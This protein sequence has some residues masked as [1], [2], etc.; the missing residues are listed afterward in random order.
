MVWPARTVVPLAGLD[1][2]SIR[3]VETGTLSVLVLLP[4]QF[5]GTAL[6]HPPE[7]SVT[8]AGGAMVAVLATEVA[9]NAAVVISQKPRRN[10]Q[11]LD[12]TQG[13]IVMTSVEFHCS[14]RGDKTRCL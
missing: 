11:T 2:F 10:R 5:G 1:V 14:L 3:V 7:I 6:S 8:P 9:A 13:L 4:V 12:K